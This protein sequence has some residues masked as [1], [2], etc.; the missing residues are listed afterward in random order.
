[1][2]TSDLIAGLNKVLRE[3][4]SEE[5]TSHVQTI[6]ESIPFKNKI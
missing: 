1:M 6:G 4:F 5:G 2:I 3:P